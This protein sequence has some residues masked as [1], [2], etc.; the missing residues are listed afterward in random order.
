[1]PIHSVFHSQY[2][3]IYKILLSA[4]IAAG[5]T[6][7]TNS[8]V[9]RIDPETASITLQSGETIQGDMIIGA[10]GHRS[11]VRD[12]VRAGSSTAERIEVENGKASGMNFFA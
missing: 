4:A 8:V 9:Q 6:I 1:M 12:V 11:F 7:R 10:D 5:V 3:T 2:P